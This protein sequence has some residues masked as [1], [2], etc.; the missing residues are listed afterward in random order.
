[1]S[2][3]RDLSAESGYVGGEKLEISLKV[4]LEPVYEILD[5]TGNIRVEFLAD[6]LESED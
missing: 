6:H 4:M 5:V 2:E 3:F 1:M